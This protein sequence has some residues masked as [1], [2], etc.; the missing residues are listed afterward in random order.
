MILRDDPIER[1]HSRLKDDPPTYSHTSLRFMATRSPLALKWLREGKIEIPDKPHLVFGQEL[2]R[3]FCEGREKYLAGKIERPAGM[4]FNEKEGK[5]WKAEQ[6]AKG[7]EIIEADQVAPFDD[8][9]AALME[10]P[11]VAGILDSY[12][13]QVTLNC[14]DELFPDLPTGGVFN[15]Q[16]RPDFCFIR[17][18]Q[19]ISINLKTCADLGKLTSG[20]GIADFGYH[21]SFGLERIIFRANGIELTQCYD[22]AV[23]KSFPSKAALIELSPMYIDMGEHEVTRWLDRLR[24]RHESGVW[25][26]SEQHH[27][28]A[29]P[30][31]WL[32]RS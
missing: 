21:T 28:Q 29:E 25:P 19:A 7:L 14:D 3:F 2:E 6:T 32:V 31:P 30:P 24:Q 16:V 23:E 10:I 20:R 15:V 1:Y 11:E 8:M 18:D 27:F 12:E 4:K 26:R 17:D 13:Q 9:V 22:L 5:T